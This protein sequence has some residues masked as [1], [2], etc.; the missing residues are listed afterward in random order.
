MSFFL[1]LASRIDKINVRPSKTRPIYGGNSSICFAGNTAR[2][3]R[4]QH[5]KPGAL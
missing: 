5:F 4:T 2:P 3:T 1:S